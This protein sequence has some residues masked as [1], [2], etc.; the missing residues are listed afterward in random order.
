[1]SDE[2]FVRKLEETIISSKECGCVSVCECDFARDE[3]SCDEVSEHLLELLD[4]QMPEEQAARLRHHVETC[5]NC[6]RLTEAE[7]HVRD[8]VRRSCCE[9]APSTLRI[10]ITSQLAVYRQVTE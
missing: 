9:A 4:A 2:L 1:M 3:C 7:A 6:S 8:I 5:P 10:R